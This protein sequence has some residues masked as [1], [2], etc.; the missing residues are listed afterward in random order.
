M[1]GR[2]HEHVNGD[3]A[4]DDFELGLVRQQLGTTTH[5]DTERQ[6]AGSNITG[7]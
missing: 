5:R 2:I 4:I 6:L 1:I 3:M 7:R